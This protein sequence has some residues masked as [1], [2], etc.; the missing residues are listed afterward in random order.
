MNVKKLIFALSVNL[1]CSFSAAEKKLRIAMSKAKAVDNTFP[2]T[3]E[4][5]HRETRGE[6][7]VT[8]GI[9]NKEHFDA[10]MNYFDN[11]KAY[12]RQ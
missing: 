10:I 2:M 8:L 7:L 4:L 11:T 1:N 12:Q 3:I 9:Y 6:Q 5:R